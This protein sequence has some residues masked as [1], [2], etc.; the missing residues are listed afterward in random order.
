M[1]SSSRY[2][3]LSFR[4]WGAW[5]SLGYRIW[6][7]THNRW[8]DLRANLAGACNDDGWIEAEQDYAGYS[9][10]RCGKARG[11]TDGLDAYSGGQRLHRHNNYVWE[12]GQTSKYVPIPVVSLDEHQRTMDQILPFRRITTYRHGIDTLRRTRRRA[13]MYERKFQE[14]RAARLG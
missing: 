12:D 9:H 5:K 6:H 8:L 2:Y 7:R 3:L 4:E 10:W 13:A 14:R 11:H 1:K